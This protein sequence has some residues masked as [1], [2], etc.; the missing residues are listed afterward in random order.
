MQDHFQNL[1]ERDKLEDLSR[2]F[3]LLFRVPEN[4]GRLRDLF[5]NHVKEEG[6]SAVR[7]A[8]S[9][10][11]ASQGGGSGL[12]TPNEEEGG[13][14][15]KASTASSSDIDPAVYMQVLLAVHNKFF[16]VAK[17]AFN[18]DAGLVASLDKGCRE[19]VNRNTACKTGSSRSSELLAKYCDGLLRKS[20]KMTEDSET[21][22]LL[23]GVMTIFKFIEDKDVFQKFYSKNLAKR[24]VNGNSASDDAEASVISQLKEACGFE[25]TT[26]L[27]R[28]FTDMSVSK[29]LNEDF[30]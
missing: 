9:A 25:Y 21:D 14:K 7:K 8:V 30:K 4:L 2:M 6:L 18:G 20:S 5:E 3:T 26:K 10:A 13:Q 27:Q 29:D 19:Y 24:L 22:T 23:S 1:L 12:A 11:E 16:D 17:T 28:M 15:K